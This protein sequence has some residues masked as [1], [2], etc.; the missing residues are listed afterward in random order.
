M[1]EDMDNIAA[2]KPSLT[3]DTDLHFEFLADP[4]KLKPR[5][6][7]LNVPNAIDERSEDSELHSKFDSA[8]RSSK[9]SSKSSSSSSSSSPS[10]ASSR[11]TKSVAPPT[12]APPTMAPPMFAAP[13]APPP[14]MAPQEER[15]FP[16]TYVP[17]Y[18]PNDERSIKFRKMELMAKLFEIQRSGRQLTRAYNIS[19]DIEDMEMEIRYQTDL[20]NKKNS[21]GLCKSFL[22][23]AVTAIEF[24]NDKFDP[25]GI[26]LN[27]WSDQMKINVDN[28]NDVF[29]EL[30]EK[31]K[32]SGR[33]M[34]PELKLILMISA[35]AAS[36][37]A[38]KT[39]T[40]S[41]GLE[42]VVKNNPELLQ[43]LQGTLSG[44]LEKKI[45]SNGQ[46]QQAVPQAN[47]GFQREMYQRMME[48]KQRMAQPMA[49]MPVPQ[50]APLPPPVATRPEVSLRKPS[51]S[52]LLNSVKSKLPQNISTKYDASETHS[53]SAS[54]R[55]KVTDTVDT[56]TTT[57][58]I[59]VN[60]IR[61]SRRKRQSVNTL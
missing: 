58:E 37:H 28:Y 4:G 56:D 15:K 44:T 8:K 38:T 9:S 2:K 45:G 32:G 24:L 7:T 6:K 49:P 54:R 59:D 5:E 16:A 43:K 23:N 19:S 26:Q 1:K 25:F 12:M 57:T 10:S 41:M 33:K 29:A 47:P 34:E 21:V 48:E 13:M 17:T 46:Q 3:T 51:I 53:A 22:L 52:N 55:I 27:G 20:E 14:P 39:M 60:S 30:Y 31:Y 18:N 35:S 36:F 11:R 40:K 50:M 61:K 42:R